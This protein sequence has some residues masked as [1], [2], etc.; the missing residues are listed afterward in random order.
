ME[1]LNRRNFLKKSA[2]TIGLFSSVITAPRCRC[3]LARQTLLPQ[4]RKAS[5]S[6]KQTDVLIARLAN[7]HSKHPSLHFDAKGLEQLRRRATGTHR[8][9]AKML[10]DWVDKN[11]RW[12]PLD[13]PYP[14]GR[15]VALEQSGAFVTNVALAFVLSQRDEHLRLARKWIMEMLE[16]PKNG[17][18]NYGFGIYAA[19]LARAYDW[20]YHYLIPKEHR[21]I[22]TN[23][24]QVVSRLY[25]GSIPDS[26]GEF[27]WAK[28]YMHHD[29]WIPVG[30]YG[31]AA[32]ALL[33]EVKDA[34]KWAARAKTDFDFALS[35]LD[36]DGAWHEG[37]A[38][39]CYTMAPLLWFYSAW[40]S[41]VGENLHNV[42]W[43]RNTAKYRLYHWLPD[44]SYVYLNDSFRSGRYN[45]SGSASC[46]L[47]RRLASLFRDGYTQWLADRDEAF[48]MKPGP[49]GVYQAPYEDLSFTG[50]PQ[51][52]PHTQ[53]QCVAWNLL[54]YDPTVKPIQPTD[55]PRARHFKN[56][57]IVIMRTGWEDDA[58]VVSL[59]CA[60]LA[61]QRCAERIRN[62]EQISSSNY[63]HA[64]ADYNSFTLFA[65]GNYFIIPPGYAR[66]SSSFQ[67]VVSVNGADF[68]LNPS[69]NVRIV[70]FRT[71]KR[72]SYAVG[73]ATEAFG[74]HLGVQRYRRHILLLNCGLMVL[75]DDL[76]LSDAGRR[77]IGYNHFTWMV[78]S[79]PTTHKLTISA[80]KV[81]WKTCTG[82]EPTLTMHLLEPQ[83]FAWERTLL[84]SMHGKN[85]LEAL[86]LR[87]SEW[88]SDRMRALSVWS[89]QDFAEAPT[90][91]RRRDFLAVLWRE[92]PD[93]FGF[94]LSPNVPTDL[95]HPDLRDRELLLFGYDPARPDAFILIKDGK[96]QRCW[97]TQLLQSV[98]KRRVGVMGFILIGLNQ[99]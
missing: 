34:S 24:V 87:R 3:L 69:I 85:M 51:E 71:E 12:S 36:D 84:Q 65:R 67:N 2:A 23:L 29:H 63:G 18:R 61:G 79:D 30:G 91:L 47:L 76:Q 99:H 5:Q 94:A 77:T 25:Q 62:G 8:R 45:T 22:I 31:E 55:L 6:G 19:G 13:M 4:R 54:W 15:E 70:G 92:T 46:H 53:S 16:Y 88:Y 81:I 57:G 21:K 14:A 40:Q 58:A 59:C 39:W 90:L 28:A 60:P 26:K 73:D 74:V 78:H 48:D 38:D 43:I 17:V 42:P 7:I 98:T 89:W 93:G 11:K 82:Q 72:F 49:K 33:G 75:F 52:Y 50:Q 1:S 66:R 35:L 20:L 37:P 97:S 32:L 56:Q 44:D 95:R 10:F 68:V 9:Y 80:N 41:V 96:V 83:D 64:H 86:R 27:W